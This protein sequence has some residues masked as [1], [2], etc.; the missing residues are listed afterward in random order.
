M[1]IVHLLDYGTG[2]IGSLTAMLDSLGYG[3][4]LTA[5]PAVI[6]DCPLLLL[7]GVGSA[8]A[9]MAELGARGL[10]P[11]LCDRH[12]AGRPIIGICLGAQLL[13][14]RLEESDTDGL[15]FLPGTVARLPERVRFN[16]GWCRLEWDRSKLNGFA[17]GLRPTDSYF[18][19]HQYACPGASLPGGVTV[20]G[21]PGIP[22]MYFTA[23]LCG[24]QFHP[25]KSQ[26]P[27]RLLMRNVL[28]HYHGR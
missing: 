20:A 6:R 15:G 17:T 18:F 25:E 5:D 22:A 28:R 4:V 24:L 12:A 16:T 1:K 8:G 11:A 26:A 21:E 14:S 3:S 27:G 23:D 2:N 10:R 7:P 9:A 19:N 13:F